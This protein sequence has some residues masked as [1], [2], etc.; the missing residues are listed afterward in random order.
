MSQT[1]DECFDY[2]YT[3]EGL[4]PQID[5]VSVPAAVI[6]AYRGNL[7]D[8]LLGYWGRLGWGGYGNGLLWLVDPR[9]YA[10]VLSAWIHGTELYGKDRYHVFARGAFGDL[11]AWGERTGPSLHINAPY[12]MLFPS[13]KSSKMAQG[14]ARAD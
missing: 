11:Y 10:D 12:S 8:A 2:F 4:G 13:D 6:D 14:K 1:V 7:P 9:D 3:D 5:S